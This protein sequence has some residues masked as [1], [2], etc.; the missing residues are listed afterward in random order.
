MLLPVLQS[1]IK[2]GKRKQWSNEVTLAAVEA[3]KDG[4]SIQRATLERGVLR[5]T[6]RPVEWADCACGRWLHEECNDS[7]I[8][9]SDGKK[10]LFFVSFVYF[11]TALYMYL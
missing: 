9:D 2:C 8:Q 4:T 7:A 5:T 11:N 3:V 10:R 1:P 6:I